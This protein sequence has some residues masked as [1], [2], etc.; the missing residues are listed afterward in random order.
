MGAASHPEAEV[1]HHQVWSVCF[2]QLNR[3]TEHITNKKQGPRACLW[4]LGSQVTSDSL[5]L[6]ASIPPLPL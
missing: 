5:S 4:D 3:E 1:L 2:L 6:G